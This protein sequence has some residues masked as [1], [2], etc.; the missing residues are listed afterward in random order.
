MRCS[1]ASARPPPDVPTFDAGLST[2]F[3]TFMSLARMGGKFVG[4][5]AMAT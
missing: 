5:P 1:S 2:S 4:P 3:D